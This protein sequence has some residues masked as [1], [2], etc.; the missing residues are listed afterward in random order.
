MRRT[1]DTGAEPG[2]C[3]VTRFDEQNPADV[4]DGD[5]VVGMDGSPS[6]RSALRWAVA[7]ARLTGARL[8]VVTAWDVPASYGWS[9]MLPYDEDL[10]ARAGEVLSTAVRDVL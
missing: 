1:L 2:R 9:P 4:A 8:H 7:Q 5:I 6:A 3:V 10:A